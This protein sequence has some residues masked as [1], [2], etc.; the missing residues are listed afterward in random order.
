MT[1]SSSSHS[2]VRMA[3]VMVKQELSLG[4]PQRT[5]RNLKR[6]IQYRRKEKTGDD[7]DPDYG[8]FPSGKPKSS[9]KKSKVSPEI[10]SSQGRRHSVFHMET[11]T[12]D[13]L[14]MSESEQ[15]ESEQRTPRNLKR[16][17]QYRRKEKTGDDGDPDYGDFPSGKPKSSAKKSKVSP[18]IQSSQ[19]RRHSVFHMETVTEDNLAMSESEQSESEQRTPRNLKRKIQYRRKEK[20]GDDGDPD[21]G[22]F[23]SGKPKSSAKKSKVS[24]EIQSS[25]GRRH[26]VF[27]METDTKDNLA[28]SE[29]EQSEAMVL[30]KI[31]S[32]RRKTE[33]SSRDSVNSM[34]PSSPSFTSTSADSVLGNEGNS[35]SSSRKR[36]AMTKKV[37]ND[38]P[39]TYFLKNLV[40]FFFFHMKMRSLFS[41]GQWKS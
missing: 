35:S 17:I 27:H 25:Q 1:S 20:T 13:N 26:S 21:Y 9:A 34:N 4:G 15:S 14:A 30:M 32:R 18:E 22:D 3:L 10:Q 23:P 40:F 5:P 12:E 11:D 8:D 29:S 28:M 41:S 19:G 36:V 2:T 16:K 33:T 24:P 31:R 6:K 7:G 37:R 38:I 39:I